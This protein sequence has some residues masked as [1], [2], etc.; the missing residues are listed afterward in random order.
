M[1]RPSMNNQSGDL[2]RQ[3]EQFTHN[4]RKVNSEFGKS[5]A[6]GASSG[7]GLAGQLLKAAGVSA[8]GGLLAAGIEGALVRGTGTGAFRN[9]VYGG[10][11]NAPVVGG[12]FGDISQPMQN[13]QDRVAAITGRIAAAGGTV[14]PALRRRL[15]NVFGEQEIRERDERK[16][17][18]GLFESDQQ[19]ERFRQGTTVGNAQDAL[20]EVLFKL[21]D[22]IDK[23]TTAVTFMVQFF[24][25]GSGLRGFFR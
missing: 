7:G 10:L 23:L 24:K 3:L 9:A 13:T 19:F 14:D 17:V 21:N 11:S 18:R 16:Q 25:G 1:P 2:Q 4:L 12:L 15:A 20:G 22:G 6:K 8:A 5:T